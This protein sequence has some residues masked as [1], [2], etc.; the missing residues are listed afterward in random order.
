MQFAVFPR[1]AKYAENQARLFIRPFSFKAAE[2]SLMVA[3]SRIS[4]SASS[5]FAV[6]ANAS[7]ARKRNKTDSAIAQRVIIMAYLK[8]FSGQILLKIEDNYIKEFSGMIKYKI[9]GDRV[10]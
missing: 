10:Q 3:P 1:K 6:M 9:N 8:N 5:F 4:T 7:L 2:A